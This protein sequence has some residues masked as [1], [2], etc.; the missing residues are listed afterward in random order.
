MLCYFSAISNLF[1]VFGAPCR[2]M[3]RLTPPFYGARLIQHVWRD[4]GQVQSMWYRCGLGPW[5]ALANTAARCAS[6]PSQMVRTGKPE[7]TALSLCFTHTHAQSF[8]PLFISSVSFLMADIMFE[9]TLVLHVP[10]LSGSGVC[11]CLK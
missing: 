9:C 10:A 1:L 8:S 4:C 5:L 3:Q 11:R 6:K 7:A 2:I